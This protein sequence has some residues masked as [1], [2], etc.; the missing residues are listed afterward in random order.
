MRWVLIVT[1]YTMGM[2]SGAAAM[3]FYDYASI[4]QAYHNEMQANGLEDECKQELQN[5]KTQF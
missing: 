1:L 5:K 2:L 3:Y 4:Q